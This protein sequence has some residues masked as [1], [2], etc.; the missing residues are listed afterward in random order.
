MAIPVEAE[1]L[2]Y[3][4]GKLGKW[5]NTDHFTLAAARLT[6]ENGR[7]L[8]VVV[9]TSPSPWGGAGSEQRKAEII[10]EV[11]QRARRVVEEQATREWEEF[12]AGGETNGV[13][14]LDLRGNRSAPPI[15]NGWG[16]D[17]AQ[18]VVAPFP[19]PEET[20]SLQT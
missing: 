16:E 4:P 19:R 13:L 2:D 17:N 8:L 1:F 14:S 9:S 3:V 18:S 7:T 12:A 10:A 15:V 6:S 11:I 20:A 5:H